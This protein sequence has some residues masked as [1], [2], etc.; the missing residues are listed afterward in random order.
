[1]LESEGTMVYPFPYYLLPEGARII[2]YGAGKMG[3]SYYEQL[4]TD[5]RIKV[6]QWIDRDYQ[7]L[8]RDGM[9]VVGID[10]LMAEKF[11]F[12]LIAIADRNV[13]M[14]VVE[15]LRKKGVIDKKI[16]WI[17]TIN[18]AALGEYF[19]NR[20]FRLYRKVISWLTEK[21][22][23]PQFF[24]FLTP[25][26][27][28]LGDHAILLAEREF[29][30]YYFQDMDL[31]EVTEWEWMNFHLLDYSKIISEEDVI[32]IQG[33]GNFG[34]L[35]RNGG[36][37]RQIVETFP[38]NKIVLLPN[39]LTYCGNNE[40]TMKQDAEFYRKQ[41]NVYFFARERDSYEKMCR[42]H[43]RDDSYLGYYPDM[44]LWGRN[45]THEKRANTALLCMRSDVE[46]VLD[47]KTV[48]R[49]KEIFKHRNINYRETNTMLER[50]IFEMQREALVDRKLEEFSEAAFVVTDRLHGMIFATIMGV[51]C[52]AFNNF[53]G[54]VEGVYQWLKELP[55][56]HY[57]ENMDDFEK[58][59]DKLA[60]ST[61][62]TYD[63]GIMRKEFGKMA[64]RI[65]GIIE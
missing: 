25:E 36:W 18:E 34:D 45:K 33:G 42:L 7:N 41:K 23:H 1:M 37:I 51:P 52:I 5:G 30:R 8:S 12:V 63:T 58:C 48:D 62:Y 19:L 13:A 22:Q 54:K 6:V 3:S 17:E 44:V 56:V 35:W 43:Y 64:E 4:K 32:F 60:V 55:Y 21:Y 38:N 29:F 40:E 10:K 27:G 57:V 59:L 31:K 47:E 49:I 9:P 26:H 15:D 46:K 14:S 65:R 20:S 53:T 2:L 61:E 11:D 28:N 16:I 39:T 50:D 24:L